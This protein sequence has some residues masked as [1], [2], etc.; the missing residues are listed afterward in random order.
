MFLG[1][2][3]LIVADDEGAERTFNAVDAVL[4][5]PAPIGFVNALALG[6][7]EKRLTLKRI[8]RANDK[9]FFKKSPRTLKHSIRGG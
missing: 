2:L 1:N 3:A 8:A 4:T 5:R 9:Y 6:I 7:D